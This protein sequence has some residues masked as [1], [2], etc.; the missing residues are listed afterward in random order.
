[1][2]HK[3]ISSWLFFLLLT[4]CASVSVRN[5]KQPKPDQMVLI[6][7]HSPSMIYVET[8][9]TDNAQFNVDRQGAELTEF[10]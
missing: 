10:K 8:F 5:P 4:G 7:D 6:P 3:Q 9:S 1:M 2:L